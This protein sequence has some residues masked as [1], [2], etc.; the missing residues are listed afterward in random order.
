MLNFVISFFKTT[1]K[2]LKI[3]SEALSNVQFYL[4]FKNL[5]KTN[6]FYSTLKD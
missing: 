5:G 3:A 4:F 1:N 2:I 6:A